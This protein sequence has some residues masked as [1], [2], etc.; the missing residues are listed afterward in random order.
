M[1]PYIHK[2]IPDR[3]ALQQT[4]PPSFESEALYSQCPAAGVKVWRE[5][6]TFVSCVCA[7]ACDSVAGRVV[8]LRFCIKR[9]YIKALLRHY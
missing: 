1:F 9:C 3:G 8:E 2:R 7:C 5:A 6:C 4:T